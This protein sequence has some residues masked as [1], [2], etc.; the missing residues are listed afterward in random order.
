MCEGDFQIFRLRK[1]SLWLVIPNHK[2]VTSMHLLGHCLISYL[3][4]TC[5]HTHTGFCS[6]APVGEAP[7]GVFL[8]LFPLQLSVEADVAVGRVAM[9]AAG[10]LPCAQLI[11]L[12]FLS[13]LRSALAPAGGAAGWSVRL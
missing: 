6:C 7:T 13:G 8:C 1:W 5:V 9:A 4:L 12:I 10:T 2:S 3:S 11:P